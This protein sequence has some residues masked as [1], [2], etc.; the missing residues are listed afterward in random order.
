MVA[1][2]PMLVAG[3]NIIEDMGTSALCHSG[4]TY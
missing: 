3:Q 1:A 2:C 4:E